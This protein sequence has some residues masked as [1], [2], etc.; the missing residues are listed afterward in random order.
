MGELY[1]SHYGLWG[2]LGRKPGEHIRLPLGK[3]NDLLTEDT[4]VVWAKL[5]GKLIGY[6][7]AVQSNIKGHGS[8]A[9]VTQLVVHEEHR[10]QDVGKTLLFT[11][12]RFTDHF[13]WG[14]LSANPYAIRALEKAT[15]RRCLPIRIQVDTRQ[16]LKLGKRMIPYVKASKELVVNNNESRINTQFFLDHSELPDMLSAVINCDHPWQLGPLPEGW[17][18]FA[19]NFRDQPQIGL[20][21]SEL[22]EMLDASDQVTKEAYSRMPIHTG[23]HPWAR[24]S[25]DETEFIVKTC[26]L[27][28]GQT[29]VDFG[30][31]PGRHDIELALN[32]FEVTGI[33]YVKLFIDQANEAATKASVNIQFVLEDC[34]SVEL[35]KKFDVAICLY[36]VIGSYAD[37]S[38]NLQL[39]DNLSRHVKPG[40]FVLL[41]VMNME[42][43]KQLARNWFTVSSEADQLLQLKP[44]N[45][46]EKSGEVF[47]PK[48]YM[49][50]R[51]TE[52][53]Y[54]KEQFKEGDRLH[55]E[56][57]VRDRRYTD[58]QIRL[59]CAN[60]GLDVVW[61]KFVKAGKWNEQLRGEEAKEILVLC[62]KPA[63]EDI[64]RKLF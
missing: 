8:V 63:Q 7:I 39:L 53:V 64:Q 1:S 32:G 9:W 21:Q 31:G 17:E 30:C 55:E 13:A 10:R 12:W 35:G 3:I 56:F 5:L 43:T 6:A 2:N 22:D 42:L 51:K 11:I 27:L 47:N 4:I 15:R 28:R 16:L 36:D 58:T 33:D 57:I 59:H 37:D 29:V 24:Y 19:F 50:D 25:T 60:A 38:S 49:I 23:K 44:S 61:S 34:R 26:Q 62:R 46:M 45:A 18:W 41:S 20:T 54:R 14:I 40:G 52:I 48:F